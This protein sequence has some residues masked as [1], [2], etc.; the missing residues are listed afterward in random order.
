LTATVLFCAGIALPGSVSAAPQPGEPVPAAA[1]AVEEPMLRCTAGEPVD[2]LD[3]P[4]VADAEPAT[5]DNAWDGAEVLVPHLLAQPVSMARSSAPP[6][7]GTTHLPQPF[8]EGP[9]RPPRGT[10]LPA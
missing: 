10:G 7:L 5:P 3:G 4:P 6:A 9:Q 8:I 2:T 1:A